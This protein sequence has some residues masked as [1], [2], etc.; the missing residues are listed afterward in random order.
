MSTLLP[1]RVQADINV[2][3]GFALKK[4]KPL[5]VVLRW[6]KEWEKELTLINGK[7]SLILDFGKE[8]NGGI[9]II[10]GV[11]DE[12]ST[13]VRFRFGE[14]RSEVET[15]IGYKNATNDHSPRDFLATISGFSNVVFGET[16]FRYARIDFLENKKVFIQNIFC[17]NKM[18]S[19]RAQWLYDGSDTKIRDIFK[20]AK[21]TVDLCV[22]DKYVLDGIKRDRLVWIGDI[23][24]EML[25]LTTLYGRVVQIENSL[26]FMVPKTPASLYPA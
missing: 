8:M 13:Q 9:R 2:K 25:A 15:E 18:L 6:D 19:K 11:V 10:T 3:N 17:E 26:N 7:G 24:P 4:K 20:T 21:R 12:N 23:H 5:T 16:G 22:T 1:K 14:S